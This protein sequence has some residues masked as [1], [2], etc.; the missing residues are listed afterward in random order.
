MILARPRLFDPAC[1]GRVPP[2]LFDG[3]IY[4]SLTTK[5]PKYGSEGLA[6]LDTH[7][8]HSHQPYHP[9]QNAQLP[10][11]LETFYEHG[12][13]R[14]RNSQASW[15]G[16]LGW[17]CSNFHGRDAVWKAFLKRDIVPG[18]ME[19]WNGSSKCNVPALVMSDMPIRGGSSRTK[20][21]HS[22]SGMLAPRLA[23]ALLG[24]LGLPMTNY[25]TFY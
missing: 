3:S 2:H 15:T 4:S 17:T 19:A 12:W 24:I 8:F 13:S 9:K 16:M 23:M 21:S 6:I 5:E 25:S 10:L 14:I 20:I 7:S 18:R 1:P 22:S 11:W